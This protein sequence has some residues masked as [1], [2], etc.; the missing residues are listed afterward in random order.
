MSD[1]AFSRS[2]AVDVVACRIAGDVDVRREVAVDAEVRRRARAVVHVVRRDEPLQVG[3]DLAH[4]G[5]VYVQAVVTPSHVGSF[6]AVPAKW[7]PSS[8]VTTKSE[9]SFVI[10]SLCIRAKNLRERLVVVLQ[11][12]DVAG[13]AGAVGVMDLA[14]ERRARRARRR[15]SR[16]SPGRRPPASARPRRACCFA[17]IPSKPGKPHWSNWSAIGCAVRCR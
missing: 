7:S 11:L 15:C 2:R 1:I 16:T 6:G 4:V 3:V 17:N 13:L 9:L 14:G 5:V 8:T 12:L 10:P